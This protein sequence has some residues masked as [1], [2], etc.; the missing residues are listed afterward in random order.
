MGVVLAKLQND[1]NSK[2][3][4]PLLTLDFIFFHCSQHLDR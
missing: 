1:S 4:A 2:E 3:F